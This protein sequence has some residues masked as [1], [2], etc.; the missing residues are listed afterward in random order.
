M[1][2]RILIADDEGINRLFI[3]TVLVGY[4]WEVEDASNGRTALELV[5]QHPFDAVI[6][7]VKMPVMDGKQAASEIRA[8]EQKLGRPP[9]ILLGLTGYAEKELI[10]ELMSLGMDGVIHKPI[11]QE[12]LIRKLSAMLDEKEDE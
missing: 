2:T 1:S 12:L 3:K 7:D 4:G 8:V 10:D 9:C 6:L 5:Q 11:T